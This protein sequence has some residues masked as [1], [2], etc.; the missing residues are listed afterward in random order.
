[1]ATDTVVLAGDASAL[2][3]YVCATCQAAVT[4]K[5]GVGKQRRHFAHLA[6]EADP[7]CEEY[8][9]S[10]VPYRGRRVQIGAP[11]DEYGTQD[12]QN[13]FFDVTPSGP[14]LYLWMPASLGTETLGG[15]VDIE[16]HRVSRRLTGQHLQRGQLVEFA[17]AEGRWRVSLCGEISLDYA[18]RLEIGPGSLESHRNLFDANHSPGRRLGP[19]HR[20]RLGDA[21]WVVTRDANFSEHPAALAAQCHAHTSVA[22]WY[23][24]YVELPDSTSAED[25]HRLANWLERQVRPRRIRVWIDRPFP[26]AYSRVGVP[27]LHPDTAEVEVQAEDLVDMIIRDSGGRV[28]ARAEQVRRLVCQKPGNG[29]WHVEVNGQRLMSFEI[30]DRVPVLAAALSVI[31]DDGDPLDLFQAQRSLNDRVANGAGPTSVVLQSTHPSILNLVRGGVPTTS[32]VKGEEAC[33]VV[34]QPPSI[35]IVAGNLGWLRWPRVHPAARVSGV[36][37]APDLYI[38]ARWLVSIALPKGSLSGVCI[39]VPHHLLTDPVMGELARRRWPDTLS[40]Q[41]RNLRAKLEET[42]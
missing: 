25:A 22:G 28:A 32:G 2:R 6:G 10:D 30:A 21:V 1:M 34:L 20:L 4:L 29:I 7:E 15:T 37:L 17:L 12:R 33:R 36:P 26:L 18:S 13:L 23:I 3:R 31:F 40:P 14:R 41:L 16:A 39:T 24:F 35:D 42:L 19:S 8:Y 27:L 11:A 9:P 5:G 38:T